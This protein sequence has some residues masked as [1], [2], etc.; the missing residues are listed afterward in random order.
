MQLKQNTIEKRLYLFRPKKGY[1]GINNN[2]LDLTRAAKPTKFS[3]RSEQ[4]SRKSS[5]KFQRL[6]EKSLHII[7]DFNN[8]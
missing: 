5:E 3:I 7:T 1:R 6:S 4:K 2:Y 8:R